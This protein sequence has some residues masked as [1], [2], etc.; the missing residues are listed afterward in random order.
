MGISRISSLSRAIM[1]Q[2]GEQKGESPTKEGDKGGIVSETPD[3]EYESVDNGLVASGQSRN[4]GPTSSG[5]E[6]VNRP[7]QVSVNPLYG[8]HSHV[9]NLRGTIGHPSRGPRGSADMVPLS[10]Y[11][12]QTNPYPVCPPLPERSFGIRIGEQM[13]RPRVN[14]VEGHPPP[15]TPVA[16]GGQS[17]RV[18]D[19]AVQTDVSMDQDGHSWVRAT[20]L[21][22]FA[23]QPT[24][25]TEC[26]REILLFSPHYCYIRAGS[27]VAIKTDVSL[28]LAR[29]TYGQIISQP[30]AQLG[31]QAKLE[32]A[33]IEA[34]ST[35]NVTL[36]VF[37]VGQMPCI[38]K[39]GD[40]LG[41]VLVLQGFVP[42]LDIRRLDGARLAII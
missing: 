19:V 39:R 17:L 38:I 3:P 2:E 4:T 35:T 8:S 10:V 1:S 25:R 6:N 29:G 20:L 32:A 28:E 30:E 26:S 14:M 18:R 13:R 37:N 27:G 40:L 7:S 33:E 34:C 5:H 42:R 16:Q 9:G 22:E 23:I 24:K 11:R 21:T 36:F 31:A 41:A 12:L 15:F